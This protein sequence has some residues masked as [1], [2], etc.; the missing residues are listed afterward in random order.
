MTASLRI[1]RLRTTCH[2]AGVRFAPAVRDRASRACR[3]HVPIALHGAARWLDGEDDSVWIVRRIDLSVVT[4]IEAAPDEIA[5]SMARALGR[6]LANALI[7]DGDG[8]NAI[9]FRNR[10]AYLSRFIVDAAEGN[11]WARWYFAP[12]SGWRLLS[13]SAAIRSA[14]VEDPVAGLDALM[15]LDDCEL[16]RVAACLTIADER[17]VLSAVGGGSTDVGDVDTVTH[18]AIARPP[19]LITA[20]R[21][22]IR[23][24][25]TENAVAKAEVHETNSSAPEAFTKFGGIAL[26][27]RDLNAFPWGAWT[28]GWFP[29]VEGV[30]AETCLKWVTLAV[31]SGNVRG[32]A[33]LADEV[34][35]DLLGIPP[36][37]R[38]RDVATWL[39]A[40]GRERRRILAESVPRGR[41]ARAERQ[42]LRLTRRAGISREWCAVLCSLARVVYTGFAR[43][44]P[45]FA[46]SSVDYLWRNFLAIDAIVEREQ[47]RVVV[48]C[49]RA[50]LHLVL[51]LTGMT[52]G[53]VAGTDVRGR[54]ILVFSRE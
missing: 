8:T 33:L 6:A 17:R 38:L 3:D 13:A 35:R 47:D 19:S 42:W 39:R 50:P 4:S 21:P 30:T 36:T 40:V 48:Q 53:L 27:L 32:D 5:S 41:V 9:R 16:E 45:G 52:R 2:V 7:D 46:S 10:G 1:G 22:L 24:L 23:Y 20:R 37:L 49:G 28:T 44:L 12:L 31:C 26:L 25:Q 11:A 29:P 14:I 34:W 43:R 18:A 15:E 54:P 51:A